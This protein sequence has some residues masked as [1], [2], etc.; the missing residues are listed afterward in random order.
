MT[1]MGCPSIVLGPSYA[2]N[3]MKSVAIFVYSTRW[4]L[5]AMG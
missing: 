5:G 4:R 2:I 1:T 3:P